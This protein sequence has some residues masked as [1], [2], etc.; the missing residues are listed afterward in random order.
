MKKYKKNTKKYKKK[1]KKYKKSKKMIGGVDPIK[2][3]IYCHPHILYY[4]PDQPINKKF[5]FK[6]KDQDNNIKTIHYYQSPVLESI[7][8]KNGW[9]GREFIIDTIDIVPGGT[10]IEDGFDSSFIESHP[11]EYD[12][13]FVPDCA[14]NWYYYQSDARASWE[15]STGILLNSMR[16]NGKTDQEIEDE[17]QRRLIN[18]PPPKDLNHF[19]ELIQSLGTLVS[20]NGILYCAKILRDDVIEFVNSNIDSYLTDFTVV[21]KIDDIFGYTIHAVKDK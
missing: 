21:P 13:V 8:E 14:G 12:L 17:R 1:L 4:D 5:I 16:I 2:M 7:I 6:V 9:I 20:K 10:L 18:T 11:N 3:L 19:L 15:R